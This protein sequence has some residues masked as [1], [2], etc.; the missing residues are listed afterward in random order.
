MR[1]LLDGEA[2]RI[3]STVAQGVPLAESLREYL[4]LTIAVVAPR[5]SS[6]G[7]S[8][9]RTRTDGIRWS[10]PPR[11]SWIVGGAFATLQTSRQTP[12]ARAYLVLLAR[13]ERQ[14]RMVDRGALRLGAGRAAV[15][16]RD[17]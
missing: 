9:S 5:S 4:A 10:A 14:E 16:G 7:P 1:F 12:L 6:T 13:R 17:W 2:S 15:A 3:A 8:G 11:P